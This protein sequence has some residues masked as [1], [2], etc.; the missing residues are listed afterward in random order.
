MDVKYLFMC[1]IISVIVLSTPVSAPDVSIDISGEIQGYVEYFSFENI[2]N[3]TY[4][5]FYLEWLNS[6]SVACKVKI[7]A[8]ISKDNKT[9]YTDWSQEK[10]LKPGAYDSFDIY[11]LAP[12]DGDYRGILT[13]YY[14]YESEKI[15]EV[16]FSA[17]NTNISK[18]ISLEDLADISIT[19]TQNT[20]K[21]NIRK[22]KGAEV[23][24]PLV[25]IPSEYPMGWYLESKKLEPTKGKI[26]GTISYDTDYWR[27][28]PITLEIMSEDGKYYAKK[29]ITLKKPQSIYP[30]YALVGFLVLLFVLRYVKK[31]RKRAT[32]LYIKKK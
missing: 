27:E 3:S 21:L 22:K 2:T 18:K 1:A 25:I 24:P 26:S 8:D 23:L 9:I 29:V 12:E 4:Q 30:A 16:R 6:G 14:C 7:R 10:L 5:H 20:I 13:A 17:V 11:W 28:E 32:K 19:N 15:K 31:P